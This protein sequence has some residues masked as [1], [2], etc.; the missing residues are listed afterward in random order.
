MFFWKFNFFVRDFYR[1]LHN[2]IKK[3]NYTWI[4]LKLGTKNGDWK[5]YREIIDK[6]KWKIDIFIEIKNILNPNIKF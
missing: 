3:K 6:L 1:I 4:D 2:F 5:F